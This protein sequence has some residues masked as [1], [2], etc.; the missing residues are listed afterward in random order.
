M[1]LQPIE[2]Y[3]NGEGGGKARGLALLKS[4]GVTIPKTYLIGPGSLEDHKR[5]ADLLDDGKSYAI[6]SSANAEDGS[7]H[8]YAG[9]FNSFLNV[10]GSEALLEAI[11]ECFSSAESASV[12]SYRKVRGEETKLR[13]NVII[14]EMIRACCSGGIF[15]A[16]PVNHRR[17][18]ISAS[19]TAGLGENLL[20]GHEEGENHVFFKHSKVVPSSRFID[21]HTFQRLIQEVRVIEQHYGKPADLEWAIDKEGTI[22]W[23]QLRP[24]T[25]LKKVHLNE[26]D[27]V[28]L[29]EDPVYT[30]GNIGEMMPG[31]VTPLTMSTFARAIEVGLQVFYRKIGALDQLSGENLFIHSFYNHLFFSMD[32]L[33]DSTR[34]VFLSKK[35][36]VDYSVVG[37]I[38]PG[39]A[40][41]RENSFIPA[42]LN[43]L[44]MNRYINSAKKA[45]SRLEMLHHDFQLDLPE[46]PWEIYDM[47]DKNLQVL[48]DA[49]SLHYVTSA[50]SGAL[51]TTILNIHSGG[52]IPQREDQE[53]VARLFNKI[54]D[55]ESA[56]VL[57]SIDEMAEIIITNREAAQNFIS[58][59]PE[60]SLRYLADE[61]PEKL[62][63][64][65]SRF[66]QRHGHRCVR[67]AEM[68]EKEWAQDPGYL[69]SGLKAK[70]G[71]LL[72]G[73]QRKINGHAVAAPALKAHGL[74]WMQ[75]NIV[76]HLLPKAR[77]AVARRERT[78]ALSI[79]IQFRFK[80][81]Y[82]KLSEKMVAKG[83]LSDAGQIYFLT[84]QEIGKALHDSNNHFW[85][86]TAEQRREIYPHMEQLSFPDLSFGIPVPEIEQENQ[87]NG[88]LTGIPV[89]QGIVE[90]KV[91][92]IRSLE[93]ARLLQKDEIMVARFT[94]I[95]WTPYYSI[96]AGLITEIGSPLSHGAVVAREY[97]M[98]AIV[99]MKG[100]MNALRTGQHIRMDAVKG[101]VILLD[102]R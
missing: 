49:Y 88:Q 62:R 39:K 29:L 21:N 25:G 78:K 11:R 74:N 64:A 89:S 54:E 12:R 43:F 63:H 53:K 73:H 32:R 91:R 41:K 1:S 40:V 30:R 31:P 102:D 33:Y 56:D 71:F 79:S 48:F 22:W 47:I 27:H 61:G 52:K 87:N 36:N 51:Y 23:L 8:S 85:R 80:E 100:A 45:A 94:D 86:D 57:H 18:L 60:N 16:D 3:K 75:R 19:I 68:Y 95:G 82:R 99:S 28:P 93:E 84:H 15:T 7:E 4:Y 38:V 6:R 69:I 35:E 9:Q 83:L 92:L 66:I 98:P 13:M 76:R 97:G 46:N 37:D 10:K 24:V 5:I 90:G 59:D 81:A 34:K 96:I 44:R 50:Q 101:E 26:L 65:W 42:F 70:T 14:Q 55:I 2:K 58:A 77:K 72:N 17:D 20:A 67:E